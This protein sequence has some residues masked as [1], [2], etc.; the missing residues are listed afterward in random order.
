[1]LT[2]GTYKI[3][4]LKISTEKKRLIDHIFSLNSYT[5]SVDLV[6]Y[7]LLECVKLLLL[8]STCQNITFFVF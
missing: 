5:F 4:M 2:T 7:S 3:N 1:M 6:S 8:Q